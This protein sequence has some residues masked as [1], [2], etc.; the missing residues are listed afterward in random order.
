[1]KPTYYT[2]GKI[3]TWDF[4][5]DKDLNYVEGNVIKYVVRYKQKN[6]LDDLLKARDY[7][8]KLIEVYKDGMKAAAQDL[9]ACLCAGL[10]HVC[11]EHAT[12]CETCGNFGPC[13]CL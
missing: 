5:I 11:N 7:L 4:I 13:G 9:S 10:L 12:Q 6:G 3:E 1:M 8:D 2:R